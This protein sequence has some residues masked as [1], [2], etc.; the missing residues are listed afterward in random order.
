MYFEKNQLHY[1]IV[2]ESEHTLQ[3]TKRVE[4]N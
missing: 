3:N 2:K 1:F 4:K